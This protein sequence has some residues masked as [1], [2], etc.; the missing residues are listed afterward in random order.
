MKIKWLDKPQKH[1]YPARLEPPTTHD[2][3]RPPRSLAISEVAPLRLSRFSVLQQC[4][5]E[6]P[7]MIS[8]PQ[9]CKINLEQEED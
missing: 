8:L 9:Y 3:R 7:L 5:L 4:S 6:P 1:D 2:P